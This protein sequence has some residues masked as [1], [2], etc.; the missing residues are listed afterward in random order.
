[1]AM[2]TVLRQWLQLCDDGGILLIQV[3]PLSV[4]I[5]GGGPYNE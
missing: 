2:V 4:E 3:L 5:V 1:M